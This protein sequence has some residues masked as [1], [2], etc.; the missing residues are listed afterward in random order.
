M[1][2]GESCRFR[3]SLLHSFIVESA[4]NGQIVLYDLRYL[5]AVSHD[6]FK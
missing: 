6:P 4:A 2:Y 3:S 1:L 5:F